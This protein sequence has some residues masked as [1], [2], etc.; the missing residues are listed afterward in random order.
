MS[1]SSEKL[2]LVVDA[3]KEDSAIVLAGAQEEIFLQAGKWPQPKRHWART[4]DV[5]VHPLKPTYDV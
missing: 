4:V 1:G 2:K 5:F 3:L